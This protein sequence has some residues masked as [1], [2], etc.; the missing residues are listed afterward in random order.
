MSFFLPP[1][2]LHGHETDALFFA[3]LLISGAVL[4]LV[5][6][7]ML[8]YIVRYRHNSTI[9]RGRLSEKSWRFEIAW[10]SATL[11]MFFGLFLWGA[12]LYVRLYQPPG[13]VTKVYVV[14][15]Q[16]MWKVE[17]PEGQREINELHVPVDRPV[18]LVMT[19]EDVI[20]DFSVPAFRIKHDVLPGRYETL[21]FTPDKI[22]S[23][24]FFCTQY[25]GTDHASMIGSVTVE[26]AEDFAKWLDGQRPADSLAAEGEALFRRDGCSGCHGGSGTVRAPAFVGLYG[27]PV[28][29]A[30]GSVRIADEGY[31]RDAI[32]RPEDQRIA[33]YPPLMPSFAGQISE[34][35]LLK[36]IAFIKA[37]SAP[38]D[39]S[40]GNLPG[41]TAAEAASRLQATPG[42]LRSGQTGPGKAQP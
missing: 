15:K 36:L 37:Q 4:A 5:M 42:Q 10:T 41:G 22:G 23:Y 29:M 17:H 34:E 38:G 25:C 7:L 13:E 26:S 11:V 14:G 1:A 35:D 28:P 18:E 33:G 20:H 8:L 40:R 24:H 12:N 21:W 9:D 3:L 16:W 39:T 2:S 31:L 32:L 6:G 30:D 27:S 19:S